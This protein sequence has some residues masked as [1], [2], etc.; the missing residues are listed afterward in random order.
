MLFKFNK[1]S[2][3]NCDEK[4]VPVISPTSFW[5]CHHA[6]RVFDNLLLVVKYFY[7]DDDFD[8]LFLFYSTT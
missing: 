8:N 1:L 6:T 7:G 3:F 4:P 5:Y 2:P